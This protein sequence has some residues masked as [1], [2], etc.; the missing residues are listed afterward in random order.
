MRSL[1]VKLTLAFLLVGLTGAG[2]VAIILRHQ[3]RNAFDQFILNREQQ[4]LVENL[5]RYYQT[6]RS[7][8]G[9]ANSLDAAAMMQANLGVERRDNPRDWS[10]F[11]LVGADRQVV[12]SSQQDQVGQVISS[13]ELERAIILTDGDMIVGWLFLAPFPREWIPGSPEGTFLANVNQATRLSGL[14][15]LGLALILGS[16]L[17]YTLTR[18]LREL[19]DATLE[20]A[21]GK[22]GRQVKV[23]SHDELGQLAK[24]FNKMSAD[25]ARAT[26]ARRQ[27][28]A[29]IAHELRSPLSVIS[30]YAEALSDGKLPG[31][32]EIYSI[33]YQETEN[34][35]R[36]V[37]DL[38]TLSLADAGELTLA[39][40][41]VTPKAILERVAARYRLVAQ[42]K[43]L[44]L[45]IQ[46]DAD[47]PQISADPER[48]SQVLDNLIGNAFRYT[49]DG[50]EIGLSA[51]V[52]N[53]DVRIQVQD[54]GNGIPSEELPYIFDRF[55]RGD[56]AR[57]AGAESGLGLAIAKS[58]VEAHGG[59]I[60]A[61]SVP[62][63]GS[64]FS[65]TLPKWA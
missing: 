64:V 40:Q 3:T 51:D 35:K 38:R 55:Y 18:T 30:G 44:S 22:L 25:L 10:R 17:A 47:L 46:A 52:H 6:Y 12:V 43:G 26:E 49:S 34:L 48:L 2:L 36:Q 9:L 23:R 20:L 57:Q 19:T 11:T 15:A 42:K 4:A 50:G 32:Q 29:D 37:N 16:L 45:S 27:M 33:L 58:I 14:V 31:T 61:E 65:I 1:A 5:R 24:S 60:S 63:K 21:G 39:R 28:T 59:S 8:D 56:K 41:P 53:G 7:W 54:N 62:G 13:R